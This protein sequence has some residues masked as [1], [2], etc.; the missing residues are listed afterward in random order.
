MSKFIAIKLIK[1]Y[2]KFISPY[3]GW[4]CS[5]S[6]V[7]GG[8]SCSSYGLLAIEEQGVFKGVS[9]LNNRMNDC[10]VAANL[11]FS[12]DFMLIPDLISSINIEQGQCESCGQGCG[13]G[14]TGA[15]KGFGNGISQGCS[16]LF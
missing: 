1:G 14:I 13:S 5:H 12:G 6:S 2:Q 15:C 3:K 11:L 10:E 7:Y 8:L 9:L 4:C 16:G